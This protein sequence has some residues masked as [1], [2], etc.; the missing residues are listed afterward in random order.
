MSNSEE[1]ITSVETWARAAE[2]LATVEMM[3]AAYSDIFPRSNFEDERDAFAF[4]GM[5]IVLDQLAD[6]MRK[7]I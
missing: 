3:H 2:W 6:D 1:K 7:A 5:G 4:Y